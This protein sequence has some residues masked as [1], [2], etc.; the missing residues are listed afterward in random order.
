MQHSN[1][2]P[3]RQKYVSK[4]K[5]EIESSFILLWIT[6]SC[7]N[8]ILL[9]NRLP[10]RSMN[11]FQRSFLDS[12]GPRFIFNCLTFS[13]THHRLLLGWISFDK[14]IFHPSFYA[15]YLSLVRLYYPSLYFLGLIPLLI[16]SLIPAFLLL[17]T[18]IIQKI[19]LLARVILKPISNAPFCTLLLYYFFQASLLKWHYRFQSRLYSLSI[20]IGR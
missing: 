16:Y 12:R 15:G 9:S 17:M 4:H 20:D 18:Y 10:W 2:N 3:I 11:I 19:T 7:V 5:S 6:F 1:C 14:P 8:K 13:I